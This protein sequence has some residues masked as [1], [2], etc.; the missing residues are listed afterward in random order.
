MIVDEPTRLAGVM[1]ETARDAFAGI[2][3]VFKGGGKAGDKGG[4]KGR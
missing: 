1:R 2:G 4:G 3:R